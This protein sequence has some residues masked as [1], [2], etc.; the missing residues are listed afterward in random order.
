M[1]KIFLAFVAFIALATTSCIENEEIT[2]KQDFIEMD[3][4]TYNSNGVERDYP[5]INRKPTPGRQVYTATTNGWPADPLINRTSG[6]IQL[7][8]NL[9]GPHSDVAQE[10]TYAV[11]PNQVYAAGTI[12]ADAAVQGTHFRTNG[13]VTI[14]ANSSFGFIDVEILNPGSAHAT[15]KLIVLELIGN[16]KYKPNPLDSKVAIVINKG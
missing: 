10:L 7:R 5:V 9:V 12:N 3:A 6:T 8:V 4:A 11:V 15:D 2:L 14:P 16:D 13:K 1:K